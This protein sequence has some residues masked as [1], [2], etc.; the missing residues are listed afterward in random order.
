MLDNFSIY[1]GYVNVWLYEA[2]ILKPNFCETKSNIKK[3]RYYIF[4]QVHTEKNINWHFLKRIN[5]FL[6]F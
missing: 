5:I 2:T 3:N 1:K 6:F 4:K